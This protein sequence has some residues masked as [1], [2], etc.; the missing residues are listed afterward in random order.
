MTL[1]LRFWRRVANTKA[2]CSGFLNIVMIFTN[3]ELSSSI[4]IQFDV[5]IIKI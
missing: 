5:V 2:L 4:V 1:E 3:S